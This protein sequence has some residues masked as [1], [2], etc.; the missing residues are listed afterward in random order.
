M[1]KIYVAGPMFSQAE[2]AFNETLADF[3]E[4]LG[5]QVFLPQ[6]SGFQMTELLKTMTPDEVSRLIFSTDYENIR[7]ND[8]FLLVLDGRVP[9][10]GACVALGLA[11]A[12]NKPCCG[13]KTGSRSEFTTGNNPMIDGS[14]QKIFRSLEELRKLPL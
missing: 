12:S 3:L 5:H 6:R 2:L 8:L 9:D 4:S 13:L 10:E 1:S 14:L 7:K 11:F